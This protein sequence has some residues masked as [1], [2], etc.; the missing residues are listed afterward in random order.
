MG[1][2]VVGGSIN[3]A[4]DLDLAV[5]VSGS[6]TS[7]PKDWVAI[8]ALAFIAVLTGL[9]SIPLMSEKVSKKVKILSSVSTL[10]VLVGSIITVIILDE[11]RYNEFYKQGNQYH[12]QGKF[13]EAIKS[14]T[15][16]IEKDPKNSFYYYRRAQAYNRINDSQ[17]A[18]DDFTK[19]I[20]IEPSYAIAYWQRAYIAKKSG[21]KESCLKDIKKAIDLGYKVNDA[22]FCN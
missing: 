10:L 7:L 6:E 9:L 1:F 18:R 17:K 3:T 12:N 14:Y 8:A 13:K 19:A 21:D 11:N 20:Q 15:Q 5:E 2:V 22:S 16:A 4:F